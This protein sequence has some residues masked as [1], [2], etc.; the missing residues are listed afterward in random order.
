MI[1]E[2]LEALLELEL[3][4]PKLELLELELFE[5]ELVELE[6]LEQELLELDILELLELLDLLV[7]TELSEWRLFVDLDLPRLPSPP[8]LL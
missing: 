3:L 6:V 5:L 7:D 8:T 4:E 2:L 1:L